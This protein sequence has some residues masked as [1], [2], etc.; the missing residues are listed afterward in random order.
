M[1]D[2]DRLD[3]S[4]ILQDWVFKAI[5]DEKDE[6]ARTRLILNLKDLAK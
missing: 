2:L 5:L 3:K 6:V 4:K 1:V